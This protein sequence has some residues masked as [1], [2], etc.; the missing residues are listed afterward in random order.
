MCGLLTSHL[1]VI[2]CCVLAF[3]VH[4]SENSF[5]YFVSLPICFFFQFTVEFPKAVLIVLLTKMADME[6]R[7]CGGTSENIEIGAL[8][9]AFFI[10]RE[11]IPA[12]VPQWRWFSVTCFCLKNESQPT[13]CEGLFSNCSQK[14]CDVNTKVVINYF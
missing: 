3:W 9:S 8:I 11:M 13:A 4:L 12:E 5:F 2:I 7:L 1:Y 6:Y 14:Y 10:A